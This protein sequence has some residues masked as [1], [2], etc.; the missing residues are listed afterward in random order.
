MARAEPLYMVILNEG[1]LAGSLCE[2]TTRNAVHNYGKA[3][4]QGSA[5]I[6]NHLASQH[7]L[8]YDNCLNALLQLSS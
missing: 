1:V 2:R 6:L 7:I 4:V 3:L 5:A 8:K